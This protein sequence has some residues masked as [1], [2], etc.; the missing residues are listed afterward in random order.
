MAIPIQNIYHLLTYAWDKLEEAELVNVRAQDTHSLLDLLARVLVS[1]TQHLLKRGLDRAYIAHTATITGIRGKMN[2]TPTLQRHLLVT[3]HTDCTFDE[4][5]ANVLHNRILRATLRLLLRTE[6]L[7]GEVRVEI[8]RLLRRLGTVTD[9]E[10][11]R[12]H[13]G[14]VQLHRN[15]WFYQFPLRVC[16]LIY[17]NLLPTEDTGHY[18]FRDFT[19]DDQQM[20]R[21]FEA[22]VRNFYRHALTD[23]RVGSRYIAWQATGPAS[24]LALLPGM[25]TDITVD[26]P[27]RSRLIIDTKYYSEAL[28]GRFGGQKFI[29]SNLY[30][31]FAY[32]KND[33]AATPERVRIDGMLLY[34]AVNYSFQEQVRIDQHRLTVC[35]IDLGQDWRGVE[36]AL[37]NL[38]CQ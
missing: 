3:G 15:N 33:A 10:L 11:T 1:G 13:F 22:F 6:H 8:V 29:A 24:A 28:T 21:L 35:T 23:C 37:L 25:Q 27:D 34:P 32:L 19:R 30:Q 16:A 4:F 26:F 36:S 7:D 20:A 17:D 9:M 18:R 14:Q 38:L 5:S 31:L 2:L 12:S